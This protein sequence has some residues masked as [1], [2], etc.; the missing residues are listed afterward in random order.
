[1]LKW[2]L[3]LSLTF[4]ST[5]SFAQYYDGVYSQYRRV[6]VDVQYSTFNDILNSPGN[7]VLEL[8]SVVNV[9][10]NLR[11]YRIFSFIISH[12]EASTW[13]YN[14]AG[15][16]I[17]LPGIWFLNGSP[18]E[19]VRKAKRRSW[20]SYLQIQKL[21]TKSDTEIETFVCDKLGYGLDAFIAGNLYL[22]AELNLFSYQGNQFLSPTIGVGF[23]F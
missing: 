7:D 12:G 21:I 5:E 9:N 20:N 13:N 15:F 2:A 3:Y 19:F 17:D 16:R 11:F 22:N 14:G 18:N 1:M 8:D 6:S 10:L 23:E 4:F